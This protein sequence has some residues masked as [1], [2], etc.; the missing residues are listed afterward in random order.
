MKTIL[1]IC[2][3]VQLICFAAGIYFLIQGDLFIG[4]FNIIV[5]AILIPYSVRALINYK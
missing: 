5:N 3:T 2:L 4:L 1:H